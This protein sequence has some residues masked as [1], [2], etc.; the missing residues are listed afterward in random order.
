MAIKVST[1]LRTKLLDTGSLKSVMALGFLK[2]YSGTVPATADAALSGTTLLLTVSVASG[3]TG[4]SLGPTASGGVIT[5]AA[6]T[7]SG[8]NAVTGTPT[9]YRFVA[10][11]DTGVNSTT[12]AR[13]QGTVGTTGT[14]LLL[15]TALLTATQTTTI[16][17]FQF[18]LPTN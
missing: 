14:D 2:L 11:G 16:D 5:K 9:F 10:V 8:V 18:T 6:E 15:A 4:L 17:S 13:I 3:G 12:E 7:W 1:G